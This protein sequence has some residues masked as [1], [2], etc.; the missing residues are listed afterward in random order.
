VLPA[1]GGTLAGLLITFLPGL[2]PTQAAI[3]ANSILRR[4]DEETIL[5][6]GGINTVNMALSLVTL[7]TLGFARN[8]PF[9]VMNDIMKLTVADSYSFAAIA[10]IVGGAAAALTMLLAR[11]AA[12]LLV[13]LPHKITCLLVILLITLLTL[14]RSGPAG[15]LVLA[16]ATATGIMALSRATPRHHLMTCI[17]VPVIWS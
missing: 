17:L 5:M 15:L 3:A 16:T 1:I 4:K 8:G 12:R 2:G 9:E 6:T 10:L 14:W 11:P 13:M 7:A